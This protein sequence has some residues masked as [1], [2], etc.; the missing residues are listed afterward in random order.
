M[1]TFKVVVKETVDRYWEYQIQAQTEQEAVE[2]ALQDEDD[3]VLIDEF[4]EDLAVEDVEEVE[5]EE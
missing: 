5:D 2:L 3:K 4:I 1:K